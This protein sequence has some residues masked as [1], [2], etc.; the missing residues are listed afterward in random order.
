MWYYPRRIVGRRTSRR[1]SRA[2]YIASR[3]TVQPTKIFHFLPHRCVTVSSVCIKLH[4]HRA[5]IAGQNF[6]EPAQQY[7]VADA[8]ATVEA[9]SLRVRQ[10]TE[11]LRQLTETWDRAAL[12]RALQALRGVEFVTAVTLV[13]EVCDFRRFPKAGDF[14]GYVGL[15]PTEHSS[16]PQRRGG[17]I[18][19][20]G[21]RHVRHVLV[22]AAWHYRRQPRMSKALRDRSVGLSPYRSRRVW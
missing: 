15:L 8:L 18:T 12:V 21:N 6:T 9:A 14:M 19:K 7:V 2:V 1:Y 20:T 11:R 17:P 5:W 16:G 22:E 10:L 3:R 4:T 13:A